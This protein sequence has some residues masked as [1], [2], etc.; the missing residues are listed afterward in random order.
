MRAERIYQNLVDI[1]LA[2]TSMSDRFDCLFTRFVDFST[3]VRYAEGTTNKYR[4]GA[5]VSQAERATVSRRR[6]QLPDLGNAS[7]GRHQSI[8]DSEAAGNVSAAYFLYA[9]LL[10]NVVNSP[11]C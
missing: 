5:W 4:W 9:E 10:K 11:D 3:R 8:A 1:L 6:P 2:F 7:A